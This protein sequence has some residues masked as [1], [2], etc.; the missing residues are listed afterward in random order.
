MK[1]ILLILIVFVS[2]ILFGCNT[3]NVDADVT[4]I[5]T[6][7]NN[8]DSLKD[9]N[10]KI[11]EIV[12][13]EKEIALLPKETKELIDIKKLEEKRDNVS[14]SLKNSTKWSSYLNKNNSY[15]RLE[16]II[17]IGTINKI[18]LSRE[19]F[20]FMKVDIIDDNFM[21]SYISLIDLPYINV[22]DSTEGFNNFKD[23]FYSEYEN[24]LIF[25][26]Y[27]INSNKTYGVD[28]MKSG[29]VIIYSLDN[30]SPDYYVSI[31]KRNYDEF[32]DVLGNDELYSEYYIEEEV[33]IDLAYIN[34][35]DFSILFSG[36]ASSILYRL[37]R[38]K[39][40]EFLANFFDN[41][42]F[43]NDKEKIDQLLDGESFIFSASIA[44][45]GTYNFS[46][47]LFEDEIILNIAKSGDMMENYRYI[48]DDDYMY[49]KELIISSYTNLC[50][51]EE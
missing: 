3:N 50:L 20:A 49:N 25:R 37:G 38:D 18:Q 15:Y 19:L 24:I 44:F 13:L 5:N 26:T 22:V 12:R 7:I 16:S 23:S 28:I 29:Y 10:E 14:L 27:I 2:L 17:D 30:N 33:M 46:F 39:T 11:I 45:N 43:I 8:I 1:K 41:T 36:S 48:I 32:N 47:S 4:I 35:I 40:K 34:G 9:N 21:N 42:N 31:T 51:N 6:S